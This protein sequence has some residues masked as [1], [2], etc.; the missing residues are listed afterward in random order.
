MLEAEAP[1]TC[2]AI[3]G[4]LE[5]PLDGIV[6]HAYGL[7]PEL[8]ILTPPA[9]EVPPENA[10]IFPIPG[11]IG[12]Y[13]YDGQLPNGEKIYDI[14]LFYDRGAKSMITVGWVPTNVFA[15]VTE[16]LEGLR[17]VG[18]GVI[19]SG[20]TAIRIERVAAP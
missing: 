15:A 3:W 6:R 12:F 7:G 13:H 14:A 8:W 10:T 17:S 5:Q 11:D 9:P 2:D 18:L 4:F 20:P 19:E 16:N 1:A